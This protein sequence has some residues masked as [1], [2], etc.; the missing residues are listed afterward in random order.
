M[1]KKLQE[2]E[3]IKN[4]KFDKIRLWLLLRRLEK[5][6]EVKLELLP[7]GNT[8]VTLTEKGKVKHFRFHL[9]DIAENFSSKAWDG[10]WRIIFFDV[11]EK[12]RSDRNG[13]RNVLTG[14]KFYKLQKSV[15]LT[16]Y[17]CESEIEYFRQYYGL[18][19]EVQTLITD[20]IEND[21]AYRLYFGLT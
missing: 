6:K 14:L 11:P 17:P 21:Q 3:E 1:D 7:D 16:P 19:S 20:R 15:Y 5:Q 13:F 10:K 12:K 9:G 4:S 2:K 8:Q 18:G